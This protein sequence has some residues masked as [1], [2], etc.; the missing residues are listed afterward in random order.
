MI[1]KYLL[2][3]THAGIQVISKLNEFFPICNIACPKL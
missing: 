1:I 2:E 3:F